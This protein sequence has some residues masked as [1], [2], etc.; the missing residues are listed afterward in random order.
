M[1]G[2]FFPVPDR[3]LFNKLLGDQPIPQHPGVPQRV[4]SPRDPLEPL[5]GA[6]R[7]PVAASAGRGFQQVEDPVVGDPPGGVED[8]FQE[9]FQ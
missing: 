4:Q 2:F 5:R 1:S 7:D 6:G 9:I 3:A 8:R